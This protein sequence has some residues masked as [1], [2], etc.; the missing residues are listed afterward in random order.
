[1][2]L[3]TNVLTH[4]VAMCACEKIRAVLGYDVV[5]CIALRIPPARIVI[6]QKRYERVARVL[7]AKWQCANVCRTYSRQQQQQPPLCIFIQR[8]NIIVLIGA[9]A[10]AERRAF[11]G[12]YSLGSSRVDM[13]NVAGQPCATILEFADEAVERGVQWSLNTDDTPTATPRTQEHGLKD[14]CPRCFYVDVLVLDSIHETP[15]YVHGD[16]VKAAGKKQVTRGRDV[17]YVKR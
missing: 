2:R 3:S 11:M 15:A 9:R 16:R 5:Q 17:V 8:L 13:G 10:N 4:V 12:V 6:R 1:M 7:R 14:S